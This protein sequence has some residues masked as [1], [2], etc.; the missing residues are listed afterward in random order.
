MVNL[1]FKQALF[2]IATINYCVV[3]IACLVQSFLI[4]FPIFEIINN[5]KK[6]PL[7]NVIIE[8]SIS[9]NLQHLKKIIYMTCS[10]CKQMPYTN[11]TIKITPGVRTYFWINVSYKYHDHQGFS[12][13]HENTYPFMTAIHLPSLYMNMSCH[14]LWGLESW[15]LY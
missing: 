4:E 6:N 7:L 2:G 12:H 8:T 13:T 15:Y 14:Q 5:L 11:Q 3:C 1:P 10:R 9:S